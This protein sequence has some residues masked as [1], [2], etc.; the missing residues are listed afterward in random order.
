M[1]KVVNIKRLFEEFR[2]PTARVTGIGPIREWIE[3]RRKACEKYGKVFRKLEELTEDVFR[4]FLS[5][6][7]NKT[8]DLVRVAPRLTRNMEDL[9][10]ILRILLDESRDIKDRLN[11]VLK[12]SGMGPATATT[13]LHICYPE[14]YPVW[15]RPKEEVL[16]TLGRIEELTGS[17][18]DKYQQIIE[19]EK[20]LIEEL[21]ESMDVDVDFVEL[22]SFLW[23][24]YRKEKLRPELEEERALPFQAERELRDFLSMYPEKIEKGLQVEGVEYETGVGRIDLLCRDREGNYVVIEL[25]KVRDSDNAVGQLLRYM[26][27]VK[28]NIAKGK[29][30]R[31]MIITHEFDEKLDYAVK[32]FDDLK[33]K[34]YAIKFELSDEPFKV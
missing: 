4:R 14:K 19:A 6:K 31:G 28:E 27:W 1:T 2:S 33:V 12:L 24:L 10:S 34:Y 7:E 32:A 18:G 9:K 16:K 8:M 26:G 17:Y 5:F 20:K 23:W 3:S 15:S 13:I 30:V 29:K 21:K 25:K 11:E 22:D